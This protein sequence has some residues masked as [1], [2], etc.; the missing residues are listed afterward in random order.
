ML[1]VIQ[2]TV[3]IRDVGDCTPRSPNGLA[4]E[5][6]PNDIDGQGVYQKAY[7]ILHFFMEAIQQMGM[8]TLL[9]DNLVI[10]PADLFIFKNATDAHHL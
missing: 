4:V 1:C 3:Q 9:Q 7:Q 8:T 2:G 10:V 6:Q 5:M